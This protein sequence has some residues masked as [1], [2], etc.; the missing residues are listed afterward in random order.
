MPE[1]IYGVCATELELRLPPLG[2]IMLALGPAGGIARL[3]PPVLAASGP[4]LPLP[5][6]TVL[7]TAGGGLHLA[8]HGGILAGVCRAALD[9]PLEEVARVACARMFGAAQ[10]RHLLRV[11]NFIPGIN[12]AVS[13]LENYRAF[14]V[15]RHEAFVETFGSRS[16]RWMPAASGVGS[17]G[18]ELCIAFTAGPEAPQHLENPLQVPA[19]S[20]PCEHGPRPPSFARATVARA[21]S[22]HLAFIS[23]TAAIRGH[24]SVGSGDLAEQLRVT[25]ENLDEMLRRIAATGF[26]LAAARRVIV[27]YLRHPADLPTVRSFVEARFASTRDFVAYLHADI[28]RSELAVEIEIALVNGR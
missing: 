5:F 7:G 1:D 25:A 20:Y 19:Y 12:E 22:M 3:G 10:G 23:G 27:A 6:T 2:Q 18:K 16:Q 21:G 9:R 13:G 26:E 8:E 28:C 4:S 14:C 15:G 17:H 11:W 24:R